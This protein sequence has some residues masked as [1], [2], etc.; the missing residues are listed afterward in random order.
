MV[1][2]AYLASGAVTLAAGLP[3]VKHLEVRGA[4]ATLRGSVYDPARI[5]IFL[6]A[7]WQ[8]LRPGKLESE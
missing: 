4:D 1:F 6:R 5:G 7:Y 3:L 2:Y 8:A